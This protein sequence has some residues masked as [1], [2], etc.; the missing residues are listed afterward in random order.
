MRKYF[1]HLLR[2]VFL[3]IIQ[4][5][6]IDKLPMMD[7]VYPQVYLLFIL[8]LPFD[9]KTIPLMTIAF[10][11]GLI[12][13]VLSATYGAHTSALVLAAVLRPILFQ[14][15]SPRE[16][17]DSIK[18]PSIADYGLKWYLSVSTPLVFIFHL[19]FFFLELLS[20]QF[21]KQ[22]LTSTFISGTVSLLLIV[23]I[24]YSFLRKQT[25]T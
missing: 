21:W 14:I 1:K 20:W 17:Y 9:T 25:T 24:Q 12:I 10:F 7:G 11:A 13:D 19:Y 3:V 22:I 4:V 2:F 6:L 15:F 8:G 16:G 18:E 5:F 23:L